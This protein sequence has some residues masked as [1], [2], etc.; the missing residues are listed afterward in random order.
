MAHLRA[1]ALLA[2]LLTLIAPA[3]APAGAQGAI[4][5]TDRG[6]FVV[7]PDRISFNAQ[8]SSS[9]PITQIVLEYGVDKRTCGDV[10][11][12]AFPD[13]TPGTTVDAHWTWE[14]LSTGSEPPG[15]TIWYRWRATDS[16]GNTAVSDEQR[17]TW[18]DT[19]YSW[20]Q[21]S[22]DDLTLHWYSG[23]TAFAQDLLA[24]AADGISRLAKLTGVRPQSPIDL[25]IY[26]TAQQMQDAILYEPSWAGGV[27]Y[28]ANNI[29]IIGISPAYL[30]WGRRTIVHE[31][32]H[33]IVGQITFSC[34]ENVPT[35]L[36]EGIAVYAEGGLD[37]R[38]Q[39]SFDAAVASNSLLSVRAISAGFSQHPDLADLSYSQSYSMVSY[40][41]QTYG[42][43]KLLALFGNLR[44]GM[45]VEAGVTA[46]YGFDLGGLED[47]WRAWL[48]AAPRAQAAPTPTVAPSPI[49]TIPIM[50]LAPTGPPIP[51]TPTSAP[52]LAPTPTD[53][54]VAQ[55]AP[56]PAAAPAPR[57]DITLPLA[58][59]SLSFLAGLALSGL[60]LVKL[61]R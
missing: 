40:L 49:P 6:V 54:P 37:D 5:I 7:F 23:D 31:L 4:S 39:L 51:P 11:A 1:L 29:T 12:K 18:I 8:I 60:A 47:R 26:G 36:D 19:A 45:T 27:A 30:D 28:P 52:T 55:A 14:M 44:D 9:S 61:L 20:Q 50:A 25:Y 56:A 16:A 33:L 15:A 2:L 3:P 22:R 32:T 38:S 24:T 13:F 57:R 21:I 46:A 10:T 59:A 48:R 53:A 34:G 43:D 17:A 41:V 58:G 35:W 42:P